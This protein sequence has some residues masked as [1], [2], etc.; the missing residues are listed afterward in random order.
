MKKVIE[1]YI[2]EIRY[3]DTEYTFFGDG[4]GDFEQIAININDTKLL[5]DY[6]LYCREQISLAKQYIKEYH[7]TGN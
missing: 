7:D 4:E 1:K 3:D 5:K 6:I 2:N